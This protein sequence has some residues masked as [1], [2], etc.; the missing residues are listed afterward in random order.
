MLKPYQSKQIV[1]FCNR[2]RSQTL[3]CAFNLNLLFI[4]GLCYTICICPQLERN[5]KKKKKIH[6]M[7]N[8]ATGQSQFWVQCSKVTL[9]LLS[10]NLDACSERGYVTMKSKWD[11]I[12]I[13]IIQL[14]MPTWPPFSSVGVPGPLAGRESAPSVALYIINAKRKRS[15]KVVSFDLF[16]NCINFDAFFTPARI[17]PED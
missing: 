12:I 2:F 16:K 10:K 6:W 7:K 5:K 4:H 1:S 11:K 13:I 14:P 17:S 15:K 9:M 3:Y 8:I